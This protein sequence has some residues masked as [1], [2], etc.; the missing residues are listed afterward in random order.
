M[1]ADRDDRVLAPTRWVSII[2]VPV[3][4]AAFVILFLFPGRTRQL[5]AWT[6]RP[7]MTPVFMGAGYLA[8][9]YFFV[10]AARARRW[11]EVGAGFPAITLFATMLLAATVL[12]WDRFNH[13]HV[14]FWA[15]L[16]LYVATP[17]LLPWLWLTNRR[18]DPGPGP[19]E[20]TV[21]TRLRTAVATGGG[22]Q[23]GFAAVMFAAPERVADLWPW[24]LSP[25]TARTLAAFVAVP[26]M[27]WLWFA[28]EGRWRSLRVLQQVVTVGFALILAGSLAH[29]S[30][31]RPGR[32]A[33]YVVGLVAGLGLVVALQVKMD[34]RA[35]DQAPG[36]SAVRTG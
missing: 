31:F 21:P 9:A 18:T 10:R 30:D 4:S 34:R 26:G 28:F 8:G 22:L 2:I 6:I 27:S 16:L 1:G 36:A 17:P 5:W 24:T 35:R 20:V 13:G 3:L 19:G 7:D 29:R 33:P 23:L 15:W 14:S 12:H 32:F 25:L 11:H